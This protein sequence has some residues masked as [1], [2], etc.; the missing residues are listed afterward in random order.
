MHVRRKSFLL[1]CWLTWRLKRKLFRRLHLMSWKRKILIEWWWWWLGFIIGSQAWERNLKEEEN[2]KR[3]QNSTNSTK[4]H[5]W[6]QERT[7]V[8]RLSTFEH[9]KSTNSL[10]RAQKSTWKLI[11]AHFEHMISQKSTKKY[12]FSQK[13]WQD[14]IVPTPGK[15]YKK[16]Q[17]QLEFSRTFDY[18]SK[19]SK[20]SLSFAKLKLSEPF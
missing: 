8:I 1:A 5:K 7:F 9:K 10:N 16:I 13:I 17:F 4:E 20:N 11:I 19:N 12:I 6:A 2:H 14:P 3:A 18:C 15:I